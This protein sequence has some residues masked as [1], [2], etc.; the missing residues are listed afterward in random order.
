MLSFLL[1][2]Q[3]DRQDYHLQ[4]LSFK[5]SLIVLFFAPALLFI[6][7]NLLSSKEY[8]LVCMFQVQFLISNWIFEAQF[9][10]RQPARP[11]VSRQD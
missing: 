4:N 1:V 7:T 2:N 9:S 6:P 8:S 11:S 10:T 5:E 3:P